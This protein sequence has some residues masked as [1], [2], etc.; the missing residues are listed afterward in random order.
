MMAREI[1][2]QWGSMMIMAENPFSFAGGKPDKGEAPGRGERFRG[3]CTMG[4][5][6][7]RSG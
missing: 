6:R 2:W 1:M 7:R 5:G 3:E 4:K